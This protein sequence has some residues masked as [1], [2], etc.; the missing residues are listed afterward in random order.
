MDQSFDNI[1]RK[2]SNQKIRKTNFENGI[3]KRRLKYFSFDSEYKSFDRRQTQTFPKKSLSSFLVQKEK[4]NRPITC[5]PLLIVLRAVMVM[6]L[7]VVAVVV[8]Q[9]VL[10]VVVWCDGLQIV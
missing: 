1:E 2:N 3:F 9:L 6:L 4:R 8:V 7:V 5:N 10:V